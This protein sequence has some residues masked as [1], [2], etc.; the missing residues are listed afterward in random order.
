[1]NQAKPPI[2]W[3]PLG[4]TIN[5]RERLTSDTWHIDLK[6]DGR[7]VLPKPGQFFMISAFGQGEI[8]ISVSH[9]SSTQGSWGH[10]IRAV[11][12]ASRALCERLVG[13]SVGVRGP[14]GN[15]WPDLSRSLQPLLIFA[16]GI[17]LAPLRPLVEARLQHA[18]AGPIHI[19]YGCRSPQDILFDSEL[20][21]WASM[22]GVQLDMTV[23]HADHNWSGNVGLITHLIEESW[24]P[25]PG[26][27]AMICGPE[28][29]MRLTA[30]RLL[31]A[32]LSGRD[33]YLSMERHMQCGVGV[34][35]H[36]QWGERII[37]KDGPIYDYRSIRRDLRARE[38]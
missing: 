37:C 27:Q 13:E 24:Q 28:I 17:G 14:F 22:Q 12:A 23:D 18:A 19:F 32:G 4:L 6:H 3:L 15:P 9:I 31:A 1:M 33:I 21:H 38:L 11:G 5:A 26:A 35:G 10:T 36:C 34:C 7:L 20:K 2:D 29:M 30:E 8:P 25:P 16:G